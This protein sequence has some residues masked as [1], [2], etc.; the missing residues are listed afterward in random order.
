MRSTVHSLSHLG[1]MVATGRALLGPYRA[2][3][4]DVSGEPN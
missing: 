1:Q 4:G 2:P 3:G